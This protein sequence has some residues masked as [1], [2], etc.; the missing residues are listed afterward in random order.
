M[1]LS[2]RLP[3]LEGEADKLLSLL[4]QATVR[5]DFDSMNW[6][7]EYLFSKVGESPIIQQ[8]PFNLIC[9]VFECLFNIIYIY[10]CNFGAVED[11]N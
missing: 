7:V 6:I 3:A 9:H 8:S 11:T 10:F 4:L 5:V 2:H 1:R